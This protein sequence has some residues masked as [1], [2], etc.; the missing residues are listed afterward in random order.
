MLKLIQNFLLYIPKDFFY[1]IS[2][3]RI[4]FKIKQKLYYLKFKPNLINSPNLEVIKKLDKDGIVEIK[5]YL[6]NEEI[7]YFLKI[8]NKEV[9]DIFE[10][11]YK[12]SEVY[13]SEDDGKLVYNVN[14]NSNNKIYEKLNNDKY[15]NDIISSY[16][17]KKVKPSST[18][19]ELKYG[20]NKLDES[21]SEHTDDWKYRVK[22]FFILEDI[23]KNNAPMRYFLNTHKEYNWKKNHN[24]LSWAFEATPITPY[25]FRKIVKKEKIVEKVCTAKA[26]SL[27]IA[28]TRGFHGGSVLKSGRRVQFIAIYNPLEKKRFR[29]A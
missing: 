24:Y 16:V 2:R 26:G 3:L 13:N 5:N 15:I 23:K 22:V 6:S 25:V 19:V 29:T 10:N 7:K 4:F 12:K 28:D 20:K 8:I 1:L 17:G 27:I 11:K 14:Y 21:I 18:V 9:K